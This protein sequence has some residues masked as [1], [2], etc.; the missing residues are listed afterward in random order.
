MTKGNIFLTGD[1]TNPIEIPAD[2]K[3]IAINPHIPVKALLTH[4]NGFKSELLDRGE[5][6]QIGQHFVARYDHDNK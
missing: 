3:A 4:V 6:S 5:T 1:I 2:Y